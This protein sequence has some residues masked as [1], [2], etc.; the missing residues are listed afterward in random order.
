MA[1]RIIY[2]LRIPLAIASI[3]FS[4]PASY[5]EAA[6]SCQK[7]VGEWVPVAFPSASVLKAGPRQRARGRA[8]QRAALFSCFPTRQGEVQ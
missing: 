2:R 4:L 6:D 8:C 1:G 5:S 7:I 3:F